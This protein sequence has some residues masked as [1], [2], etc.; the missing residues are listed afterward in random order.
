MPKIIIIPRYV[1]VFAMALYNETRALDKAKNIVCLIITLRYVKFLMKGSGEMRNFSGIA[2]VQNVN[3]LPFHFEF[4][5]FYVI[6]K[7]E[8]PYCRSRREAEKS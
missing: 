8:K 1:Q 3:L 2:I 6:Q 7:V 5:P 4:V